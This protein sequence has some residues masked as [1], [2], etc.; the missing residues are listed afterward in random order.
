MP[1][2]DRFSETTFY[3]FKNRRENPGMRSMEN[4]L[5]VYL[6]IE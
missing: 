1:Y 6:I 2:K 4:Y 3:K 5:P